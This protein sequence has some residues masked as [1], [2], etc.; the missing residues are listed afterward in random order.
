MNHIIVNRKTTWM[1]RDYDE[2]VLHYWKL[3]NENF[4]VKMR[5]LEGLD[6]DGDIKNA[7]PAYLEAF[8]LSNDKRNMNNFLREINSFYNNSTYYE[9][10]DSLYIE[11]KY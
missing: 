11:K 2:N 8:I 7:L 5:K 4:I 6:D 9:D 3:Q 1:K 10:T